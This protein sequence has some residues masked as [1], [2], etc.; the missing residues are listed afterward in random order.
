M[1]GSKPHN[2]EKFSFYLN[3]EICEFQTK[4]ENQINAFAFTNVY[5]NCIEIKSRKEDQI[6]PFA[7]R[8][9]YSPYR[10]WQLSEEIFLYFCVRKFMEKFNRRH[11]Q[12]YGNRGS[13]QCIIIFSF[14]IFVYYFSILSI[15]HLAVIRRIL[16]HVWNTSFLFVRQIGFG[17][18]TKVWEKE[19]KFLLEK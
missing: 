2:Q 5:R 3:S 7:C 19:D 9:T 12:V 18:R 1:I 4:K 15:Q 14:F 10:L 6:K 8:F 16:L 17:T 13:H 11:L